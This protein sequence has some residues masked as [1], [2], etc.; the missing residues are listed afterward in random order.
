[1]K[2][3]WKSVKIGYPSIF[4]F[5]EKVREEKSINV[6]EKNEERQE[7]TLWMSDHTTHNG[8]L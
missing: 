1:M 8:I 5:R 7:W 3:K 4:I 6:F 2:W